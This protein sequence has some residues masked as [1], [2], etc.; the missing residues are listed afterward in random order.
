MTRFPRSA[1][2]WRVA[3]M[4]ALGA[5]LGVLLT[6]SLWPVFGPLRAIIYTLS[7]IDAESGF[8]R[9]I[10]DGEVGSAGERGVSQFTPAGVNKLPAKWRDGWQEWAESPFYSGWATVLHLRYQLGTSWVYYVAARI[11]VYGMALAHYSH[12]HAM[13]PSDMAAATDRL[14]AVW[15]WWMSDGGDLGDQRQARA[16][17][18]SWA[19]AIYLP[20]AA[21]FAALYYWS[22]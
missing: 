16:A 5:F 9:A 4:A 6:P 11:P 7:R 18:R 3:F 12:V 17:A 22:R 2:E 13:R 21:L 19:A 20:F 10:G 8:G 14:M 1:A 15:P